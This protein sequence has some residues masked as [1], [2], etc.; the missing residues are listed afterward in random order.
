VEWKKV[1]NLKVEQRD[2][3][4]RR[5]KKDEKEG[6][7]GGKGKIEIS[8]PREEERTLRKRRGEGTL[9]LTPERGQVGRNQDTLRRHEGNARGG[10]GGASQTGKGV[11]GRKQYQ[12]EQKFLAQVTDCWSD[13]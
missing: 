5:I 2:L 13:K 7:E 10:T 12:S 6:E 9:H 1:Q 8:W 4:H 11:M 3:A